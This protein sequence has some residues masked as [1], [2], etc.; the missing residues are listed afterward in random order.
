MSKNNMMVFQEMRP[1][2]ASHFGETPLRGKHVNDL[3][4]LASG[5]YEDMNGFKLNKEE[6]VKCYTDDAR[7][8]DP[9]WNK[10]HHVTPSH[11]NKTNHTYYKVSFPQ[12]LTHSLFPI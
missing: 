9:N 11:F 6:L 10:R 8:T 4:D 5:D 1:P 12:V 3:V 2:V 7:M